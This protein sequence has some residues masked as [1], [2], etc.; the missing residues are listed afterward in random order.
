MSQ[1]VSNEEPVPSSA[2]S[3]VRPIDVVVATQDYIPNRKGQLRLSVGDIVYVLGKHESGWWDGLVLSLKA[4]GKCYRGW[5]PQNYTKSCRDKRMY[6][7]L[8]RSK[9]CYSNASSRLSSRRS[10]LAAGSGSSHNDNGSGIRL[11]APSEPNLSPTHSQ[12][13]HLKQDYRL[14]MRQNR[15]YHTRR[16]SQV[17]Q[18]SASAHSGSQSS[19]TLPLQQIDP[20]QKLTLEEESQENS[21]PVDPEKITVLSTEEVEMIFNN[22]YSN[23]R[24]PIWTPIPTNENK[25][26]YYN[27]DYNIYCRTLP[28]LHTPELNT[29]SAFSENDWDV[30]LHPRNERQF[31]DEKIQVIDASEMESLSNDSKGAGTV[32]STR[33]PN[34][35]VSTASGAS[36]MGEK[37]KN[38]KASVSGSARVSLKSNEGP[39]QETEHLDGSQYASNDTNGGGWYD[40]TCHIMLA[41]QEL[42]HNHH[43]DIRSWTELRDATLFFSRKSHA[44]FLRNEHHNFNK[45]FEATTRFALYYHSA[46]RLLRSQVLKSNV[47]RDVKRLLK[48]ITEATA[49]IAVDASLYFSSSHRVEI[50]VS[51]SSQTNLHKLSVTSTGTTIQEP[52]RISMSTINPAGRSPPAARNSSTSTTDTIMFRDAASGFGVEGNNDITQAEQGSNIGSTTSSHTIQPNSSLNDDTSVLVQSFFQ[53]VDSKFGQF[54]KSIWKLHKIMKRNFAPDDIIP[55]LFPRYF[56]NTFSGGAWTSCFQ[57]PSS[58]F[59]SRNSSVGA[60]PPIPSDVFSGAPVKPYGSISSKATTIDSAIQS[61][62]SSENDRSYGQKEFSRSKFIKKNK[63]PLNHD[64]LKMIKKKMDYFSTT[65]YSSYEKLI[66]QPK[67]KQRNLE[68]SANCYK[69]LSQTVFILEALENIDLRFFINMRNLGYDQQLDKESEELR[70]HTM[71]SLASVLMEFFDIK[72]ALYDVTIKGIMDIQQLT[73]EDPFVFCSMKGDLMACCEKDDNMRQYQVIEP[74]KLAEIYRR[75]LIADDVEINNSCFLD[76]DTELKVT[77]LTF[78]RILSSAYKTVELLIEERENVLNYAARMMKNDLIGKLMKGEQEKWFDDKDNEMR[79]GDPEFEHIGPRE[80]IARSLS[81]DIPWYLD[82]EHEYSLIYDKKGNVKGGTKIA[83]LEHLTNHQIIDVSFNISMLLTFRSIFTTSELLHALIERYNLYPPEGLSYEEYSAWVE[84]KATPTKIRVVNIMKTLFSQYWTPAYY[85]PGIE[86]VLSFAQSATTQSIPGSNVLLTEIKERLS[87]K[88]NIKSFVPE[89]IKFTDTGA[90]LSDIA[91]APKL[92]GLAVVDSGSGYGFR[93]RKLRI[94]DIDPQTFAK[95]LTIKEH[96]LYSK[97][98]LFECLDRIWGKKYCNFGGSEN[99]SRFISSANH[100]TNYVSFVIVKQENL[101]KRA[102]LIQHFVSV[103]EYCRELNN[104]SSMT[105]IISALYSSPIYRL[106]KTWMMISQDCKRILEVLNTLMDSTRNFIRYR[107][108]L[109]GIHDVACVPFFGVYLSDLTFSAEGNPD[110]LHR[111]TD[112]INFSKRTRIVD[113]LKEIASYQGIRYKFKRYDDIQNFLEESMRN[114]P[115]IE[116]QYELSLR[117]EPRTDVSTGLDGTHTALPL[118]KAQGIT[119]PEKKTRFGKVKKRSTH[120]SH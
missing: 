16:P 12:S 7:Q 102:R 112:I 70:Q 36:S 62:I 107:E 40:D 110:Y 64:T 58:T 108:W 3:C 42:F 1:F 56:R 106:K 19:H 82:S 57:E 105:A 113:I 79:L 85:E 80:S 78:L 49:G 24:P 117:V 51:D 83:L 35:I 39:K 15:S 84:K 101:K 14:D 103:A 90:S 25:V 89:K 9:S 17:S 100:L 53:A 22:V 48:S 6:L 71:T 32:S 104:F 91:H 92:P 31:T 63:Y 86:D 75:R 115:N 33:S 21:R 74:E 27:R 55:Q 50:S 61:R 23:N 45:N 94:L 76:T 72:Q 68:I 47:R 118:S 44:C 4:G 81:K 11:N 59:T 120:I 28:F 26:I 10:S 93:M 20:L 97:I 2:I 116:K 18:S 111:T 5:F 13:S 114:V 69:E 38:N 73:L 37:N 60:G 29:K 95:Q 77:R 41:K 88:G 67:S 98:T 8:K 34:K 46:C 65:S 66:E 99:I 52:I 87:L 109:K 119:K 43:M 54:N 96:H 30:D